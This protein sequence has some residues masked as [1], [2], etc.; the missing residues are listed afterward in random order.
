MP[1]SPRS[2]GAALGVAPQRAEGLR[3]GIVSAF[4]GSRP[5]ASRRDRSR[6][7][8]GY[9]AP[10]PLHTPASDPPEQTFGRVG[11]AVE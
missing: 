3:P 7:R 8:R 2:P 5:R 10:Q 1:P 9:S 6:L 4:D 11:H